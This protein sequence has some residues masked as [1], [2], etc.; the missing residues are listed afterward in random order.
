[1]PLTDA[2]VRNAT[3]KDKPYR[4]FDR[5]GLYIEVSPRGGK[6][7]RLKY[8]F[9][10]KEKRISLGTYPTVGLRQARELRDEK[11][12]ILMRGEDPS[13]ERAAARAKAEA[14]VENS[15]KKVALEWFDKRKAGWTQRT[16]TSTL[17]RMEIYLFPR[18]GERPIDGITA[19]ELLAVAREIEAR[20]ATFLS[21]RMV[22][23][24]GRIFRY[25]I[26]SGKCTNDPAPSLRG[27]L[28]SHAGKHQPAVK[29]T[30]FPAL[31]R[32]I[33]GYGL[34]QPGDESTR[35]GLQML[36][37]TFVRTRELIEATW[38]EFDLA[39]ATWKIDAPR[40]K[41]KRPHIVPLSAQTLA[42]LQRIKE[43]AGDSKYILPGRNSRV[44]MSNNTLLFALYRLGYRSR[45]TGHGFRSVASTMLNEQGFRPDVIER[46]LAHDDSNAIR[47]AYN[48]AE[49]LNERR[50]MMAW[51]GQ[52]LAPMLMPPAPAAG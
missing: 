29:P 41:M 19:P 22:Q 7:W 13:Q 16:A 4:M 52:H 2:Q 24:A 35:L 30:E 8:Q 40:M 10:G 37:L 36:A 38:D 9:A 14:A 23:I 34:D 44:P 20:G 21:G 5:N 48:H 18:L 12:E 27:A 11:R 6:W 50:E 32:A 3:P 51:W 47:S 25:G 46:Q 1:M 33:A 31:M 26:A 39:R 43:I 42:T 15:F 49:Y 17:H 45:M 28:E